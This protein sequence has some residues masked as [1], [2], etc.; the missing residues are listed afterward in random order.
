MVAYW[1]LTCYIKIFHI[2]N[3]NFYVRKVKNKMWKRL[4]L[5][6]RI[7]SQTLFMKRHYFSQKHENKINPLCEMCKVSVQ[8]LR[9]SDPKRWLEM[10]LV[11]EWMGVHLSMQGTQVWSLA[12]KDPPATQQLSS[13]AATTGPA[14]GSYWGWAPRAHALQQ[15][16]PLQR[17]RSPRL[18]SSPT[19]RNQRK[20]SARQ[21]RHSTTKNNK[22]F[23]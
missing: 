18:E 1:A 10:P 16:K 11:V 2:N 17:D 15:E 19:R 20:A 12:Q 9:Q 4:T 21:W 5:N 7:V 3:G 13:C 14:S 22:H 6:F 8:F 23:F